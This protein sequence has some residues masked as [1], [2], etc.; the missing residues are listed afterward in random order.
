MEAAAG[1][2]AAAEAAAMAWAAVAV[3]AASG[4]VVATATT[5]TAMIP[6]ETTIPV[7]VAPTIRPTTRIT[8]DRR[9]VGAVAAAGVAETVAVAGVAEIRAAPDRTRHSEVVAPSQRVARRKPV[10]Q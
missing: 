6:T 7:Q 9:E 1:A 2:E 5:G 3:R 10:G 8:M 4:E